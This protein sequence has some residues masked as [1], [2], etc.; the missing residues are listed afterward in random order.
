MDDGL[1]MSDECLMKLGSGFP[2]CTGC[3]KVA[4][5]FTLAGKANVIIVWYYVSF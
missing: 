1:W 4:Q 3:Q 5:K 2:S